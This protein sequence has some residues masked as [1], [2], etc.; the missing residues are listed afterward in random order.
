M[1]ILSNTDIRQTFNYLST[2]DNILQKEIKLVRGNKSYLDK[3][4]PEE[5][6]REY[7][8]KLSTALDFV[9]NLSNTSYESSV[10]VLVATFEKIVFAKYKT[11]FGSIKGVVRINAQKPLDYYAMREK[12]VDGSIDKLHSIIELIKEHIDPELVASLKAIKE[13]RDY[14]AHGK[15]FGLSPSITLTLEQIAMVLDKVIIEIEK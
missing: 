5:V 2:L 7:S 12:F 4:V 6:V 8:Q 1:A 14:F 13:Q 11:S 10:I 3:I 15:R 9:D